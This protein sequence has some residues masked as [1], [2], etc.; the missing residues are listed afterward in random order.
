MYMVRITQQIPWLVLASILVVAFE[1][2]SLGGLHLPDHVAGILFSA[3][4]LLIGTNTIVKGIKAL[5]H[6]NFRSIN[7]LMLIAVCGAYY[8]GEYVEA[9]VVI[10][11]FNLAERLEDIG[12]ETSKSALD[13]LIDKMPKLVHVKGKDQP[14]RISDIKTGD[15]IIVKPG[16]M[17]GLDGIVKEGSSLVD[18]STITGEP[19]PQDKRM[20][21]KVYAGTMNKQGAVEI[22]VT[23]ASEKSMVSKIRDLTYQALQNKAETQKFIEQF[24]RFYTP[25]ILLL[26][27]AWIGGHWLLGRPFE[28]SFLEALTLL[29]IACPCALVISTPISIFSAIGNASSNGVLI[30]G[31]R[32][33]E[34]LANVKAIAF[35][36]T[37][38]LTY[39]S[40]EVSDVIPFGNHSRDVILSCAAGIEQLSEHPLSQSIVAAAKEENALP[41]AV[42][43]F[44]SIIGK[45]AKADCLV[46]YDKHHCLGKLEF[47]LEEHH[48][49]DP[50]RKTIGQLQSQGKNVV[51]ICTNNEVEGLIAV[52][53]SLRPESAGLISALNKMNILTVMLTGDH[54]LSAQSVAREVGITEVK[55]ELLPHQKQEAIA[56]LQKEHGIVAMVGDGIND[57]PA[58]ATANVGI[59]M[60]FLGSDTAL[61]AASIIILNDHLE[62]IPY[63]IRLGKTTLNTIK[64]N[65]A[66]ALVVKLLIIGLALG[67]WTNLA[68]AI[69][70]DVGVTILVIFNSLRLM[71]F[72]KERV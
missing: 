12:I 49:P 19:L 8:L 59:S 23:L 27:I 50:I 6:L 69:F 55:S 44:Q 62:M 14:V 35:D 38:T 7:L 43:N 31:G 71:Q 63:L 41:H 47:I 68:L 45:G 1:F 60:S 37:R 72:S 16:E 30:K 61:E 2:L 54:T 29:V 42:E 10:V 40:P 9:A 21:D 3:I 34:A 5:F 66:F 51:V 4:I 15:V 11:L 36:K 25:A 67:G 22:K 58:L 57:A 26:A 64:A 33:L 32:Y 65:I 24:S 18:E 28:K 52:Q 53:D 20:G 56:A 48:V 39:G 70:A 46:C 13:R 17:I